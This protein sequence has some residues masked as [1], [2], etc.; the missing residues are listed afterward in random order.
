MSVFP[1]I[2][3]LCFV[4]SSRWHKRRRLACMAKERSNGARKKRTMTEKELAA[5]CTADRVLEVAA[6]DFCTVADL[7]KRCR[8]ADIFFTPFLSSPSFSLL[9]V[10]GA[11]GP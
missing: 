6:C 1:C 11:R 3:P 4:S 5:N 10:G 8:R 2:I 7:A 9:L